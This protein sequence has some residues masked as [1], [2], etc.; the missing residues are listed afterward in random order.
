MRGNG[1]AVND[2]LDLGKANVVPLFRRYFVPTLLGMLGMSA[3]TSIDGVFVGHGIGSD[4]IAAVN[5][6]IP[7]IMILTGIGLMVGAGCSVVAAMEL[8]KGNVKS[9]RQNVIHALVFVTLVAALITVWVLAFP[10]KAARLL[11]ASDYLLPMVKDYL[12]WFA[13]SWVFQVWVSV[14]LFVIRLDG[15][16]K[17]AMW[18]SLLT[19]FVN[20][21]LDWLFIFPLGW[22]IM[23]AALA[24]S[25]SVMAGGVVAILYLAFWARTLRVSLPRGGMAEIRCFIH[26]MAYQCK[27]GFSALLGEAT[28][29][30]QMLVGN[31]VFMHYLSDDGVGA[32]GIACYYTP[33]VFMIGNAIA[34]SAQPIISY[35]FS[36][37]QQQRVVATERTA[38]LT[39][40]VY[41][42]S[43][44]L[45]F[46]FFPQ[47]LVGLF[48]DLGSNAANIAVNGFPFFSL[49]FVC[50]IINL[51][52]IGYYQSV[53]RV[54]PSVCFA[55]LR[56]FVFLVPSLLLLPEWIGIK[57]IW[58][59][60]PVSELLTTACIAMF[61][62]KSVRSA[63]F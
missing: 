3:V 26:N 62:L 40:V 43:L 34:Q 38:L 36:L 17:L 33:F 39:A 31:Y 30:V 37:G 23:G 45:V 22:G 11:G 5:I 42:I 52:A 44:S 58:L 41:G 7:T 50:F 25:I 60:M 8:S 12:L 15:M 2:T 48:V 59:G 35:N 54:M 63:S 20:I 56:G 1:K 46:V 51:T 19:A 53:E 9:A 16:P 21:I 49:G 6:C 27:I 57:G 32:F 18:C 14:A 4:G 24:S 10:G 13:P 28:L 55:M 29:A 47:M 61:Y